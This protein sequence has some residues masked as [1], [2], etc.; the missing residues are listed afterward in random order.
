MDHVN[1]FGN[2]HATRCLLGARTH[3]TLVPYV[4]VLEGEAMS[5]ELVVT[6]LLYLGLRLL[7]LS[8]Q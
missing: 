1:I 2:Q 3:I 5:S 4:A 6:P 7:D 8:S